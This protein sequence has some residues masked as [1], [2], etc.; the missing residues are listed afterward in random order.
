MGKC[1]IKSKASWRVLFDGRALA[2]VSYKAHNEL[3]A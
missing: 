2:Y 1:L 3:L